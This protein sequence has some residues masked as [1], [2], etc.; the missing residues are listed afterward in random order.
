MGFSLSKYTIPSPKCIMLIDDDSH[1]ITFDQ[2][3]PLFLSHEEVKNPVIALPLKFVGGFDMS[4]KE[5]GVI[6]TVQGIYSMFATVVLFPFAVK[7]L[8]ALNLFK[9]VAFSYPVL[10]V[11]TPYVI[12]LP[13]PYRL[14]G[15]FPL[16]LWKTT[17]ANFAFPATNLLLANTAPSLLLLGTINGAASSTA[18]FCRGLGPLISGAL[19]DFGF[20]VGYF[21][22]VWWFTAIV[23]IAG[24]AIAMRMSEKGFRKDDAVAE[25]EEGVVV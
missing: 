22:L 12:L 19:Y 20:G 7:R 9:L 8:G 21:G 6:L 24:A 1:T 13:K 4:T 25:D 10:Y 14:V 18:S 2:L 15:L 17:F 5:I 11:V 3:L 16:L 23:A